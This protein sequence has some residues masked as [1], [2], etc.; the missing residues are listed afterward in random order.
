MTTH[1]L[2]SVF[3]VE[4][5]GD[6]ILDY[7]YIS[8]ENFLLLVALTSKGNIITLH[9]SSQQ[10]QTCSSVSLLDIFN[11]CWDPHLITLSPDASLVILILANENIILIPIR[12]LM[13]ATWGDQNDA[14]PFEFSI[15]SGVDPSH[16]LPTSIACF[17]SVHNSRTYIVY[18]NSKFVHIID[19]EI[20]RFILSL[21]TD[22]PIQQLEVYS[23]PN[24]LDLWLIL[25]HTTTQQSLIRIESED[26]PLRENMAH[27]IPSEDIIHVDDFIT[28]NNSHNT[29]TAYS[30]QKRTLSILSGLIDRNEISSFSVPYTCRQTYYAPRLLVWVTEEE[31]KVYASLPFTEIHESSSSV[32][33]SLSQNQDLCESI[34]CKSKVLG[35]VP[36]PRA[37]SEL[38]QTLMVSSDGIF[39]L[40]PVVPLSTLALTQLNRTK[41]SKAIFLSICECTKKEPF[42]LYESIFREV[43]K[44]KTA[45]LSKMVAGLIVLSVEMDFDIRKL[46]NLVNEMNQ[47]D[48]LIPYLSIRCEREKDNLSA[49]QLLFETYMHKLWKLELNS[50]KKVELEE[51]IRQFLIKYEFDHEIVDVLLKHS[52]LSCVIVVLQRL[53]RTADSVSAKVVSFLLEKTKWSKFKSMDL[54]RVVNALQWPLLENST[55]KQLNQLLMRYEGA[56]SQRQLHE[57]AIFLQHATREYHIEPTISG[58][59]FGY[60]SLAVLNRIPTFSMKA[61]QWQ[62]VG[63]GS[64][65]TVIIADDRKVWAFGEFKAGNRPKMTNEKGIKKSDS[66][67]RLHDDSADDMLTD[68]LPLFNLTK[69]PQELMLPSDVNSDPLGFSS[70]VCGTEHTILLTSS[71][72]VFSYGKNR[73]GQCVTRLTEVC[74][75]FARP[76]AIYA[77]HYHSAILDVN[78][79][80]WM[81]GWATHGQLAT[82]DISNAVV[83]TKNYV[84]SSLN[85][86]SIALGM[87]HSLFLS[88]NGVVYGCG[89]MDN[90]EL[91]VDPQ[92][93]S[94]CNGRTKSWRLIEIK[95]SE[96][97]EILACS[98][99]VG[100]A[101]SRTAI[102]E[103]GTSPHA[104]KMNAYLQKRQNAKIR[105][106]QKLLDEIRTENTQLATNGITLA[107]QSSGSPVSTN[108][109]DPLNTPMR[110]SMSRDHFKL[111]RICSWDLNQQ[112]I[113]NL[114]VGYNHAAI[115]TTAGEIYTWGRGADFQLG[116][117]TK[118][119]KSVP[120]QLID[121]PG[122]VWS[123]VKCG[124][125]AT[126]AVSDRGFVFCFGR[127]DRGQLAV[128]AN[129]S[130]PNQSSNA[131]KNITLKS[132]TTNKKLPFDLP[133]SACVNKPT[134]V[135]GIHCGVAQEIL[136]QSSLDEE[137]CRLIDSCDQST[138]HEIAKQ[139]R[140]SPICSPTAIRIQFMA[141]DLLYGADNLVALYAANRPQIQCEMNELRKE[142][143]KKK[144][145]EPIEQN[146][147]TMSPFSTHQSIGD[148]PTNGN[149]TP[150]KSIN[151]QLNTRNHSTESPVAHVGVE[152][153]ERLLDLAWQPLSSHPSDDVR[154]VSA[155][156]FLLGRL[157][158]YG[159]L[160][161]DERL[162]RLVAAHIELPQPNSL[163]SSST[164]NRRPTNSSTSNSTDLSASVDYCTSATANRQR[165]SDLKTAR[166]RAAALRRARVPG[167]SKLAVLRQRADQ[168]I[169]RF[170]FFA[171]CGHYEAKRVEGSNARKAQQ[172]RQ[173]RCSRCVPKIIAP[174]L[175]PKVPGVLS[176]R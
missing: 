155:L 79:D 172:H 115:L 106:E 174:L 107:Q 25:T 1:E 23:A 45:N 89:F 165:M 11:E 158:S 84:L 169:E 116:H 28:A 39:L 111:R 14:K 26:L 67:K 31:S 125:N 162:C 10:Q 92:K 50:N 58:S 103:W 17:N 86:K 149:V 9:R 101:V 126:V 163:T 22:K 21:S 130:S 122:I 157:P 3:D 74:G 55:K 49:R 13:N 65:C 64:N 20:R 83:P 154:V 75:Q 61:T 100:V 148:D 41:F 153:F 161:T 63:F 43:V 48:A 123:H 42:T 124:R 37:D 35:F 129:S 114:S 87:A 8:D 96:P 6:E 97:I 102:Y 40:K 15:E 176:P 118:F 24:S 171:A 59:L 94:V 119:D 108:L 76:V 167:P 62:P 142:Q 77:G 135:A 109:N 150:T 134:V 53:Q 46:S 139:L 85:I 98:Y 170:D 141:G 60:T 29:L 34:K 12:K 127:N 91:L 151:E 38:D 160:S 95:F 145:S 138:L 156:I 110:S 18:S 117:G 90:G 36:I 54:L 32:F 166:D 69:Q 7:S 51:D 120:T 66:R 81:F 113:R 136:L 47:H 143:S 105:A 93:L 104:L 131:Q 33:N 16:R 57:W 168:Q 88:Q 5:N 82:K 99:F 121:P 70:V 30:S 159:R 2:Q 52:L 144:S 4:V 78:S 80:V 112:P 132:K 19:A 173:R 175:P 73:Y 164:I 140:I 68:T 71:G 137:L 128:A 72:R 133:V 27:T 44:S 147:N 56:D 152:E 146:H